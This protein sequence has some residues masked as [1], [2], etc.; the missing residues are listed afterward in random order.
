M[1][2]RTLVLLG[3]FHVSRDG[4]AVTRFHSDKVRALLAYLAT[5][6]GRP[7]TRAALAAL[8]W[9]EQD[10]AAA[11]RNLS[12]TLVRL[13]EVLGHT[14]A[15][16]A[17]L[18]TTWQAIQ[19]RPEAAEVD[20][21]TFARL[22]RSTSPDDLERAAD[23][24]QG[25]FLAGFALPSCEAFEEW[26]LLTR[27]QLQQQALAILNT[28]TA[29][30]LDARRWTAA[31]AAARRQVELDRWREEAHRQLMLALS[32]GGDRA[33]ALA[34]Y[35]RCQ[36][37]LND[38]L[39][40]AP[41]SETT[42]LAD[43]IRAGAI[44]RPADDTSSRLEDAA[45]PS[46]SSDQRAPSAP[47]HSLPAPLTAL[48]GRADELARI[49]AL[50]RDGDGRLVTIVGVGGAGKTRLALAAAWAAHEA[51][52]GAGWAPLAGIAPSA[53]PAQQPDALAAPV[54][55]ALGLSFDGR[56]TPLD[57]LC[58]SMGT[59]SL[60]LVL[61]NCEHLPVAAFVHRLLAAAPRLRVIATSRARL[62]VAGEQLVR[63]EGLPVPQ[64]GVDDP[65]SYAGVQLFL[66]QARRHE[67]NFGRDP[68]DLAGAGRLCR[69]L[70]GLPLGIE[71]AA[72][73]VGHY[74]CDE[75]AVEIQADLDFLAI[76]GGDAPERH[77]SLRAAFN[78]S[79]AMLRVDERQ[80][81]ARLSIFRGSFDRAAALAVAATRVTT[82][83]ALV[84]RSL[85]RHLGV[86]RYG[87]HELVRQFAA[88]RLI[89]LGEADELATRHAG[90]FLELMAQQETTLYG[91]A[92]QQG[93]AV[94][95]EASDNLQQAWSWAIEHGA[96]DA[97]ARNL[98]ALRQHAR[99][100][101]LFYEYASRVVAAA[102]RLGALFAAGRATPEQA[103]LLGRLRGT[104]A[105]FLERQEAR[106]PAAAAAR[107]A[108]ASAA[109]AGDA[110]G[111]A[112][113]HLQLSTAAV[114]YIAALAPQEMLPAVG[115]LERA[116]ALCRSAQDPA[117]PERRYATEVEAECLLKLST[118][119][120]E[121]REYAAACALAE[122]AL[123]LT[124]Q[125][126]DRMHEARALSFSAMALENAGRYEAAY[127]RRMAMLVLARANCSQPQEHI[128]LNNLSCTL[129]YLGDYPAALEYARAALRV[130]GEWMQNAYENA[131]S[132]HTLSWAACRAGETELALDT[133][134]SALTFA[135]ATGAAQN[136]MLPLLALGDALHDLRRRDEAQAAYAAA[137][138]IGREHDM[139]PL[140]S[141][142]L[143]GIARCRLAQGAYAEARLAVDEL[144]RGQDI[145]TLGSLWEP[146]R[147]A[148]TCFRVL[149]A[150][151][152][153]R[154][155]AILRAAAAR[156]DQQA[157]Q[158]ADPARRQSFYTS[159]AAHRAIMEA[160]AEEAT[161]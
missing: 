145:L 26:L 20:V 36:Q 54:G 69:L 72:R 138:A 67:P 33:A 56:R 68:A 28:L 123:A 116:I 106:G 114:P 11:L 155:G 154:A 31:A 46:A 52:D 104:E 48:I 84:D 119:R 18:Q 115:W 151:G 128:A 42:A 34:A 94:I 23:L 71:L 144:L 66:T 35:Q 85:L 132:Y 159:V 1:T 93:A 122:Q 25:E 153:P 14:D 121:L 10:D 59:R 135:Q 75:I 118:I 113:G 3:A 51:F 64:P 77:Q 37:V 43:A 2:T 160:A 27:E 133:A 91:D 90:Y 87:F 142:A 4:V 79:W 44:A 63:L 60:L 73:W 124:R 108:I 110:L 65:A 129:L 82:L 62:D 57:D 112:Y 12:Q 16:P 131:D 9:P 101:G 139:P 17:P 5:E 74:T 105:Y 126:G 45:S 125:N 149:R 13:R 95:R 92:P 148:E 6:A 107:A 96:W 15:D 29:Q 76:Q 40:I 111:E 134:R 50:L 161:R 78:Y 157:S 88:T 32:G 100:D 158:I 130:L 127:E 19:W 39:G 83:A 47:Q 41:D 99:I 89:E 7:H 8:F 143:S 137:L 136:Q 55:A 152:D 70:D 147:V 86:G 81:L 109:A 97:I 53:D 140:V 21:A 150:S 24:Y 102:Q 98:P 141:V 30:H 103:V 117:P 156:L 146:L 38:D 22:A 61:D 80:A 49:G 58:R 120:I